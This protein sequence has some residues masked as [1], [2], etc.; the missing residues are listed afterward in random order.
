MAH[1]VRRRA[2]AAAL[3][4]GLL[5][6]AVEA[7]PAGA[8]PVDP[9]DPNVGPLRTVAAATAGKVEVFAGDLSTAIETPSETVAAALS[10][11]YQNALE[12]PDDLAAPYQSRDTVVAPYARDSGAGLAANATRGLATTR[13]VKVTR[14]LAQ[15]ERIKFEAI[16]LT[17]GPFDTAK[18][19]TTFI[20]AQR[21][22]VIVEAPAATEEL[23]AALAERYGQAVAIHLQ[24]DTGSS[25]QDDG[26]A[27]DNGNF[28]G[29][30]DIRTNVGGCT[31]GFPFASGSTEYMVTA[32]HCTT[33]SA[34]NSND[35]HSPNGTLIGYTAV[36][37][38]NNGS[39]SVIVSGY[40]D[41]H[42][43]V[44][45]IQLVP[46]QNATGYVHNGPALPTNS[47]ARLPVKNRLNRWLVAGD[48][49]CSGGAYT[50]ELCGWQV[51]L[52]NVTHRYSTGQTLR[53]GF[54][55]KKFAGS[56]NRHGDSGGPL[57]A[58]NS[59]SITLAV[60]IH[61]GG[62]AITFG[63]SSTPCTS[64]GTEMMHVWLQVPG[65]IIKV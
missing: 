34:G 31:S 54:I 63:S 43:D 60:G 49:F 39:G 7:T 5:G 55:A 26:R 22:Q 10:V 16:D 65:D 21:N 52:T 23:R 37:S 58:R 29:G 17:G 3:I 9:G 32:G 38:W 11:A 44:A 14:S 15:L 47:I 19:H 46:A 45:A 48:Q 41:Y 1:S 57:Y 20:D 42:G 59:T 40:S 61:S 62:T 2:V 12:H 53:N 30:S 64:Y 28:E 8:D 24:V 56:C 18:I 27:N 35:A 50:G 25:L 4:A 6:L 36:D 51:T 33:K 13:A